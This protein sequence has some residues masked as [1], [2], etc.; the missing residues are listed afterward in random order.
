MASGFLARHMQELMIHFWFEG[1]PLSWSPSVVTW[2]LVESSCGGNWCLLCTSISL[3]AFWLE[4]AWLLRC[5][6][7]HPHPGPF[8]RS[9]QRA[10]D[11]F[12]ADVSSVAATRYERPVAEFE[13]YMRTQD[14]GSFHC[15][16]NDNGPHQLIV[17]AAYYLRQSF[18]GKPVGT[19]VAGTF[20]A[21]LKR[22]LK[23]M[24]FQGALLDVSTLVK[25][26]WALQRNWLLEV[27]PEFRK[28]V[29]I[30]S[31]QAAVLYFL[32]NGRTRMAII[33]VLQSHYLL[34]PEESRQVSWS[35]IQI[36]DDNRLGRYPSV[37]GIIGI[38]KPKMRRSLAH[39]TFQFVTI[40][41]PVIAGFLRRVKALLPCD[42]WCSPIWE[43]MPH[44]PDQLWRAAMR[45]SGS[46]LHGFALAGLRGGGACLHLAERVDATLLDVSALVADIF[47]S[48]CAIDGEGSCGSTS[49]LSD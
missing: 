8:P 7:V 34:R 32:L 25:P 26:L 20:I 18:K 4:R 3:S 27:P 45:Y 29:P 35:S 9:F 31:A 36:F 48:L 12:V 37:F 10:G 28:P 13:I 46:E 39:A 21:G 43:G 38:G 44:V 11:L 40:E 23:L 24:V 33:T 16:L 41:C 49:V 47:S 17:I 6:D 2:A 1:G 42:S 22:Y 5:G 30:Y 14:L 15:I 19:G